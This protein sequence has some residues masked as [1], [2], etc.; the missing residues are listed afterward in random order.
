ME[1]KTFFTKDPKLLEEYYHLRTNSYRD[2]WNFQNFEEG[3][4]RFDKWG[5]VVVTMRDGKVVGGMRVMFSDECQFLSNEI[6]GTQYSYEKFI[7]KYDPRENIV[8]GEV[9]GVVVHKEHRNETV[10]MALFDCA[11]KTSE[12]HGCHYAFGVSAATVCR[13]YRRTLAKIGYDLEIVMNYPWK[14][15]KEYNFLTMFPMYVRFS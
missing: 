9:S 4:N 1:E 2:D 5:H 12:K 11:F 14:E 13:S 3:E 15:K 8:I 10:T 6:P 7:R